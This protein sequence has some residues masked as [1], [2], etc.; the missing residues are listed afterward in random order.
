MPQLMANASELGVAGNPPAGAGGKSVE[1]KSVKLVNRG[2]LEAVMVPAT[3]CTL[4]VIPYEPSELY[5][6][7]VAAPK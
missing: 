1:G 4:L 5:S 7:I 2:A 3:F 6:L